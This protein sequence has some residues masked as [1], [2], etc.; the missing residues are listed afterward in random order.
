MVDK[1]DRHFNS[2]NQETNYDNTGIDFAELDAKMEQLVYAIRDFTINNASNTIKE[3]T[4]TSKK[5]KA[6]KPVKKLDVDKIRQAIL[7][8]TELAKKGQTKK[9]K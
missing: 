2:V 3:A 7:E 9:K 4:K 8:A 6:K 5:H 1:T